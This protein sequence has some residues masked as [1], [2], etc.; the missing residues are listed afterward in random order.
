MFDLRLFEYI[1][2]TYFLFSTSFDL[3]LRCNGHTS[4]TIFFLR[5]LI[6]YRPQYI[7]YS[8]L[9]PCKL[10]HNYLYTQM[11]PGERCTVGTDGIR[12]ISDAFHWNA[13]ETHRKI[14]TVFQPEYCFHFRCFPA[15]YN[16][17]SAPFLQDTVA[18]IF[19]LGI[20]S[21]NRNQRST[22]SIQYLSSSFLCSSSSC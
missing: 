7:A 3:E 10:L 12:R 1:R 5:V 6:L 11:H 15:G 17:F 16:D 14:E 22:Q 21:T 18:G 9:F 8:P 2:I 20:T 19:V 4:R 13:Q